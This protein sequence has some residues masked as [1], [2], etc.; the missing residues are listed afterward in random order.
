MTDLLWPGAQRAAGVM[1][2]EALV[3]ALVTVELQWYLVL[4]DAG[5]APQVDLPSRRQLV[6]VSY[7]ELA[8][9]EHLVEAGGNLVIPLLATLRAQLEPTVPE[10]ARWLHKG[11]TSQD[12][13]DSAL[14]LLLQGV[15]REVLSSS[16][17]QVLLLRRLVADHRQT[18]SAGRTLTQHAVPTT[19][20]LLAAGWL[21]SALDVIEDF[22]RLIATLPVQVG[23]AAG[24]LAAITTLASRSGDPQSKAVELADELALRLGLQPSPPWHTHRRPV[25]RIGDALV[26]AVD[27]YSH[28]ANDVLVRARPEIGELSEGAGTG[29]GGS[30]TMPHK[31]NPILSVLIRRAGLTAP[32]LGATL[33]AAAAA[34]VDERPDGAWHAEWATLATLAKQAA[35]AGAQTEDLL[36]EL[37]VHAD[38]MQE[39]AER[40][41][42]DLLAERRSIEKFL[43][44]EASADGPTSY[45]GAS[46][47]LV[48]AAL[49]RAD[50]YIEGVAG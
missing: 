40:A 17:V 45:L 9:Q 8:R 39:T 33:H 48:D 27:A 42:D 23:G 47:R 26:A 21:H 20:G 35:V 29:R 16:D 5:I 15:C 11:L 50:R 12:A 6:A 10:V 49:A 30:S 13:L 43:G 1:S 2:D 46:D 4:A 38:R 44:V 14:M 19:F 25:T 24:T 7:R 28:I 18:V 37:V 36:G 41:A 3:E 31:Q 34:A 22:T 32:Q